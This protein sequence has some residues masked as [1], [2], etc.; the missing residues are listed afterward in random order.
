ML[1]PGRYLSMQKR[2]SNY[3]FFQQKTTTILCTKYF[4]ETE[5]KLTAASYQ[6]RRLNRSIREWTVI[7]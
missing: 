7:Y 1:L 6:R 4:H 3:Q 5:E 2:M